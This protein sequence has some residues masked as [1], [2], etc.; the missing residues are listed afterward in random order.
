MHPWLTGLI[1]AGWLICTAY[2][3]GYQ[4]GFGEGTRRILE[5]N[6]KSITASIEFPKSKRIRDAWFFGPMLFLGYLTFLVALPE[7][8]ITAEKKKQD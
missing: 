8:G 5:A 6:R 3:M 7:L 4:G 1:F 2:K